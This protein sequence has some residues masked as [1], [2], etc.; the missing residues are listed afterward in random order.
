MVTSPVTRG[1]LLWL[2]AVNSIS[3]GNPLWIRSTRFTA[4]WPSTSRLSLLGTIY[5]SNSPG[6]IT[7]PSVNTFK[8]AT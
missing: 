5:I 4:S 8:P 3:T 1:V 7:P 2:K 6:P